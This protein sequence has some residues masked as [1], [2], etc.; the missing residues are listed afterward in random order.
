MSFLFFS[1]HS[2]ADDLLQDF[3]DSMGVST[4]QVKYLM[5]SILCGP[6]CY[7]LRFLPNNKLLKQIVY[8]ILG[9]VLTYALFGNEIISVF[10]TTIPVY[11]VMLFFPTQ[12]GANVSFIICFCYLLFRHIFLYFN[13]YLIWTVDFTTTHMILTL[14]LTSFC[15]S[16][17]NAKKENLNDFQTKHKIEKYPNILDFFSFIFFFPGLF[18]GPALEYNDFMA[19]MDMSVFNVT[20][21]KLPEVPI[22]EFLL[23]YIGGIAAYFFYAFVNA[24]PPP[25]PEYYILEHPETCGL[26]WKLMTVW[27]TV[28]TLR[29]K[30][31]ATWKLTE[32]F[33]QISACGFSGLDKEGKP[34]FLLYQNIRIIEFETS[35]SAKTNID[36]WNMYVQK[37]L[38]NYVYV[39]LTGTYFDNFKT[40]LTMVVS[41]FWHGVYPGYYLTFLLVGFHKDVSNLIYK[42]LDPFINEKFGKDSTV[43]KVYDIVLRVYTHWVLNYAVYPFMRFEFIPSVTMMYRTYFLGIL[44]PAA[45]YCW[46]KFSPP[47]IEKTEKKN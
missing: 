16:V 7:A 38:K 25:S 13:M 21:G 29:I 43:A 3:S 40:S 44:V 45:I 28:S 5:Y 42:K 17:A 23:N 33:G 12:T 37:W 46:L 30:Y 26:L 6:L 2:A 47:K 32:G 1:T 24:H 19:F 34:Q 31:Y 41:A 9:I 39:A 27:V 10:F 8:M 14:K 35:R 18:S 4:D 36:N 15:F 22:V 20:G 11:L